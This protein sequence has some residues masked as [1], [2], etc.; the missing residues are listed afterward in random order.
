[1]GVARRWKVESITSSENSMDKDPEGRKFGIS[2][3][4]KKTCVLVV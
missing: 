2:E 4:I 3:K 1:M